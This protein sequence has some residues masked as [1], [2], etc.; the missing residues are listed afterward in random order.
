MDI[1]TIHSTILFY[2]NKEQNGYVTHEE[3]D[4]V[5]DRAQM[6]LF[7]QY[8]TN[9]K[10][11][12]QAQAN[13]YGESQRMD[14]AL[15]PFKASYT[16][17]AGN[18]PGGLITLPA[19]Y[20]HL[21]NLYTTTFNSQLGRN[22]YS[23]V[24]MLSEEELVERLESQVIP[25]TPEDPVGIMLSQNRI[26]LYPAT[27]ATGQVNYFTRPVKPVFAYTQVGRVITYNQAGSTQML[28]KDMDINNIIS[29]ALSYF[30]LNFSSQEVMQFAE[31]KNAQGQ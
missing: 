30:G 31:L 13:V 4:E 12:A 26:Q 9:P 18:T 29:T 15:S 8:H 7:N 25:V 17:N 11:P 10:L 24:Q 2:L 6:V 28:W 27:T 14:D 3:I 5:L 21:I 1:N 23:G 16:L 20:M 19:G 22:V